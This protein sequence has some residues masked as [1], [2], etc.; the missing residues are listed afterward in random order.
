MTISPY[1]LAVCTVVFSAL[2]GGG[3][4]PVIP[5]SGNSHIPLVSDCDIN[6]LDGTV[7]QL[8]PNQISFPGGD[9]PTVKGAEN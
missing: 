3:G 7:G 8:V 6:F 5:E 4:N 1:N 9:S 2:L